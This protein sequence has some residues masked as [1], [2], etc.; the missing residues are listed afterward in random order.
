MNR[1]L[2]RYYFYFLYLSREVRSRDEG[3]DGKTGNV[4]VAAQEKVA[5]WEKLTRRPRFARECT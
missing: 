2:L 3:R 5:M 4:S 1:N